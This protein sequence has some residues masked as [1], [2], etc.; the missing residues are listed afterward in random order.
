[1][2][3]RIAI[4]L[5]SVAVTAFGLGLTVLPELGV[6]AS[7][8]KQG[9]EKCQKCH[10]SEHGVWESSAHGKSFRDIHKRDKA[11]DIAKKI[12]GGN[13]RKNALCQQCHFTVIDKRGRA[14][15]DAGP[16]C[17]SCHGNAT[18]WI[19]IHNNEKRPKAE[20]RQETVA[21]GMI[22]PDMKYDI[23][24][25]CFGCHGMSKLQGS[26]IDALLDA[27]HPINGDYEIVRYSQG[28]VRHRFYPPNVKTNA[29]MTMAELSNFYAVGQ[30]VS[31]VDAH[32]AMRKSSHPRYRAALQKRIDLAKKVIATLPATGGVLDSPSEANARKVLNKIAERD[33]SAQIGGFL[34]AE[35]SYK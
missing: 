17:E 23:A 32:E 5:L 34:P 21:M 28:S 31:L 7:V 4:A 6:S 35:S 25:N 18:N 9:P 11:K 2:Q 1:M 19:E 20:R 30:L 24:E 8:L 33:L 16:S 15:P 27:G 29:K 10:K 14:R 12:G 13:M 26:E 3:L 22:W